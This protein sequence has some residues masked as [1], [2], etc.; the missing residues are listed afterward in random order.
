MEPELELVV[1]GV[2]AG[3]LD[4][5]RTLVSGLPDDFG[6]SIAIV[7]HRAKDSQ[8]LCSLLQDCC[9]LKVYEVED[10]QG[11]DGGAVYLAPPDYHLL[12]ERGHFAL[13]TEAPVVFSRPSIDVM[14]ESAAEA[15]GQRVVG[16]VLT[17]A[18]TDGAKGLRRIVDRGGRAVVQDPQSAEVRIMPE[19]AVREVPA[20]CVLPLAEIAAFLVEL[21]TS[22]HSPCARKTP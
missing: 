22:R 3:G 13:S 20:A 4:A 12:I 8:A 21:Q 18:N 17:G 9:S 1:V 15:Y 19:A 10:K 11:I 6:L 5:L 7:Q 2:S 14:F 16:V